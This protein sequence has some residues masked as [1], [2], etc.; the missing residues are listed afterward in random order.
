MYE[1]LSVVMVAP[2]A[3]D[4]LEKNAGELARDFLGVCSVIGVALVASVT[5]EL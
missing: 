3:S 5:D 1:L 2:I 4:E